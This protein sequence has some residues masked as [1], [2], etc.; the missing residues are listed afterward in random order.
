MERERLMEVAE[1]GRLLGGDCCVCVRGAGLAQKW[2]G[3]RWALLL[4][5]SE[6]KL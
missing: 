2:A 4:R 6:C 1:G 5:T 3:L